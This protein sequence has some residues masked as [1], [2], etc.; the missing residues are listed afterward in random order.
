MLQK[1]AIKVLKNA[2]FCNISKFAKITGHKYSHFIVFIYSATTAHQVLQECNS[3]PTAQ[4]TN[5]TNRV[6]QNCWN[7]LTNLCLLTATFE[8][9]E[10]YSVWF[11]RKNYFLLSLDER[12]SMF[13]SDDKMCQSTVWKRHKLTNLQYIQPCAAAKLHNVTDPQTMI[14]SRRNFGFVDPCSVS[15]VKVVEIPAKVTNVSISPGTMLNDSMVPW[16][17]RVVHRVITAW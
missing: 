2:K 16:Q 8:Y 9:R 15:T 14:L 13:F 17:W 12:R 4:T 11:E 6:P 7:Y 3:L 5:G 1:N 10:N